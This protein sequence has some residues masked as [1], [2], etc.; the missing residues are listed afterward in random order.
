MTTLELFGVVTGIVGVWMTLRQNVWCF[1]VGLAN[2]IV[3]LLLFYEQHLY[4]DTL[5]QAVYIPLLIYGWIHWKQEN[6]KVFSP[7]W[8]SARERLSAALVIVAGGLFLGGMLK[9]FTTAHFPW[10]DSMATAGAFVAQYL[11]ARK[12]TENWI[13]WMGVNMAYI[14]IYF[15]KDLH[16][17]MVLYTLYLLLAVMGYREWS[18]KTKV[19][20]GKD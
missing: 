13:L 2:V 14:L 4:A 1:P 15:Y 8:M 11:V 9:Q 5:Q 10:A 16:G 19:A 18:K 3:S 17:Y 6:E 7:G 20:N 12:K